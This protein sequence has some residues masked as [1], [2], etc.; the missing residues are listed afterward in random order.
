MLTPNL[1]RNLWPALIF[2]LLT[3]CGSPIAR[4]DLQNPDAS[5]AAKQVAPSVLIVTLKGKLGT[6][7]LARCYRSIREAETNGC[8]YVIF[9]LEDAGATGESVSDLQSLMDR[10]QSTD[11]P[12]IA[13]L[14]GRVTQGAAALALCTTE[15]YMLKGAV[16]GEVAKPE[17]DFLELIAED[18]EAA[19]SANLDAMVVMM[20]ARL[21]QRRNK[22]RPDAA[23]LAMAMVDPRIQL[24]SA[25][26][27]EGGIERPRIMDRAE[28]A[29]LQKAGATII[30]DEAMVRP[31]ILTATEAEDFALSSGTLSGYGQL[32]EWKNLDS[33][34]IG[35]LTENWAERMV[36]WLELLQPF[37]L[38]AGFL[39][40]LIEVK[41]PGAILPGVIGV[42]FLV[43]AM[44]Y[45]YLVGLAEVTEII[46]FFLGLI[47]IAVEIFVL[48][49]TVVFGLVGFLC[50][51]LSLVLSRQSFVLPSNVVEEGLL[52]TNL[53]QLTL[54]F[55]LVLALGALMWRVMPKVPGFNKMFLVPPGSGD[56]PA[57]NSVTSGLGIDNDSLVA[58]VGRTGEAATTLKP[59][60]TI[61]LDGDRIDVV[62]EGEFVEQG[63]RVRV[64]YVEGNRVVVAQDG[65]ATDAD[66]D[67][68]ASE[69]GSV[70]VVLLMTV[71]GL[72]LIVAEVIFVSMGVLGIMA[73][74]TLLTAVFVAF[75]VSIEFGIAITLFEAI[76]SPLVLMY[77][78]KILPK[79]PFGKSL[80]LSGPPT[81]GAAAAGDGSLGSLVGKLGVT[82]SSLRPSGY[83]RV[84][85]QKV[86]VVTRGEMVDKDRPV[87]VIDVSGNRVVVKEHPGAAAT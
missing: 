56:E 80:I 42:G 76:A 12:T 6:T 64:L 84:N 10:V 85:N 9:R 30:G 50:L 4:V 66:P 78:F 55:V 1:L 38:I 69:S 31:L 68:R 79:T 14:S 3:A 74:G 61:E 60:G 25:T 27:R 57:S 16:W 54:M 35:E 23:K 8:S 62:T 21:D 45:S 72:A 7:E 15:T 58:L 28:L 83:A 37:L 19:Q 22:L 17:K 29:A 75:Q 73:G 87:V 41:M 77:S 53:S 59:T 24:V 48:P 82:T 47:A 43:L 63:A 18:P 71:I 11:V 33:N 32:L 51:I 36:G 46:V 65:P 34:T 2:A 20:Q 40:L 81:D 70:G 49:G 39:F 13:V 44:V 26:V 86:D 52:V 67:S 5:T